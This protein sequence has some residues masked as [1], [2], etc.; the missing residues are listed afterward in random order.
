MGQPLLKIKV[1]PET[2]KKKNSGRKETER[3]L[4]LLDVEISARTDLAFQRT[5]NHKGRVLFGVTI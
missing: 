5:F 3:N 1:S 2:D 4:L